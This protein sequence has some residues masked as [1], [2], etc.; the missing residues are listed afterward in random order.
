MPL[1]KMKSPYRAHRPG[2]PAVLWCALSFWIFCWVIVSGTAQWQIAGGLIGGACVAIVIGRTVLLRRG[3]RRWPTGD[4]RLIGVGIAIFACMGLAVGQIYLINLDHIR[5]LSQLVPD[6][7]ATVRVLS[8]ASEGELTKQVTV[9]VSHL[10]SLPPFKAIWYAEDESVSYGDVFTATVAISPPQD[11]IL[12]Y[13]N[14]KGLVGSVSLSDITPQQSSLHSLVQWRNNFLDLL[15]SNQLLDVLD[16]VQP[17]L[18]DDALSLLSALVV[19]NR[20]TLFTSDLYQ[21]VKVLGLAHLVAVS[22]AHLVIVSGFIGLVLKAWN[23]SRKTTVVIQLLF[24]ILYLIMVAFP[25]SCIRAALMTAASLVSFGSRR[26]SHAIS[27]LA[28]VIVVL[29]ALDPTCACS[30]S[31]TLSALSTLGIVI[32]MPLFASWVSIKHSLIKTSVCDPAFMTLS[33]LLLTFPFSMATFNQFSLLAPLSNVLATPFV[34]ILCTLGLMVFLVIPFIS[35]LSAAALAVETCGVAFLSAVLITGISGLSAGM[36]VIATFIGGIALGLSALFVKILQMMASLPLVAMPVSMP[37]EMLEVLSVG[38]AFVLWV[39]WPS[40][41]NRP[42]HR[43]THGGKNHADRQHN[44]EQLLGERHDGRQHLGEQHDGDKHDDKQ[45][46]RKRSLLPIKGA[47]CGLSSWRRLLIVTAAVVITIGV[48]FV[49]PSSHQ[50]EI[51]MFDVGQGDAFLIRSEGKTLL[52]DTGNQPQKLYKSLAQMGCFHLDGILA[53]HVDDDHAGCLDDLN[54]VVSCD[55]VFLAQGLDRV[56]TD[57]A[58]D[59]VRDA[60]RLLKGKSPSY[61]RSGDRISL[62]AFTLTILSPAQLNDEGGNQ[63][64]ICCLLEAEVNHDGLCD[65]RAYFCGDAEAP[66]TQGLIDEG[67]LGDLDLLK[68]PHHG[69]KAGLTQSIVNTLSPEVA[70]ISVGEHNRYGHPNPSTLEYLQEDG[71]AIYRS[72]QQ[73]WVRC[74]FTPQELSVQTEK[75]P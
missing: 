70:L 37:F 39:K 2:L 26:R 15:A 1:L 12:S 56:N 58:Q 59:V 33:A 51:V 44:G 73:G 61:V 7:P 40:L 32:F 55:D 24:L 29:V 47:N 68:V 45:P 60:T 49:W 43:L 5:S 64:S 38:V 67:K 4:G 57:K 50:T 8:D 54:G 62:G 27:S 69:A 72:D 22:G 10:D 14:Q 9:E 63:D 65:W 42:E 20:T 23:C 6:K 3:F 30:L 34:G 19:G 25:I 71:C 31:F 41:Q 36:D 48:V 66:I 46:D 53:S 75:K 17:G 74:T 13:Y 28:L 21:E 11:R 18:G 35:L 16:S 52:V